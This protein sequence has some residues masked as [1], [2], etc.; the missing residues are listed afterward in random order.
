[1]NISPRKTAVLITLLALAS[2][3]RAS[4]NGDNLLGV[5]ASARALGGV[6]VAEPQDAIG[7]ISSNP[8]TLSFL[9]ADLA[10]E[11]DL[12]FTFFLPHVSAVVGGVSADS[13]SKTYIIPSLA[14][15]G[16]IGDKG[17]PWDYGLAV[18]GAVGLGVDYRNSALAGNLTGVPYPIL[19]SSHTQLEIL[20]VAP[21]VSYRISTE[22]SAGLAFQVDEG[23]LDLGNGSNSGYGYGLQPGI[24][25][26][27]TNQLGFGLTYISPQA[28]T[29]DKVVGGVGNLKL[30]SPQQLNL[31][32]SYDVIP[33]QFLI[34]TDLQW[35]NWSNADGYKDFGWTNTWV[36]G[37]G[38]QF[39]AIPKTLILRAGYTF[40]GN[41]VQT[42]D[43]WNPAGTTTVQG[44]PFPNYYYEAF[45]IVGFPAI[46]EQHVS[47]GASFIIG[48]QAL[49]DVGYTHAFRH[50]VSESGIGFAGPTSITS[51]LSE[52]SWELGFK[53]RF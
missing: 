3:S 24:T 21:S 50:T 30:Q 5:G 37:V 11:A 7:A 35:V 43:N 23:R 9:G 49:I 31:G 45:R 22:W 6:G 47:V 51:S 19:P 8:A 46:V 36:Y 16:P 32:A 52:D 33:G 44:N 25:F 20:K 10:S 18:Y 27:P 2:A 41:P 42:H 14:I 28:I 40:G 15:A 12:S 34:E 17:S 1:M 26:H 53:Y 4:T 39:T 13:A 29:Y 48:A 38:A